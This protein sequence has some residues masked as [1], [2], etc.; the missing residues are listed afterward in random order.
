MSITPEQVAIL[1]ERVDQQNANHAELKGILIG[2]STTQGNMATQLAVM[3]TELKRTEEGKSRL[4]EITSAQDKRLD[5]IEGD[6]RVHSWTWKL[7]GSLA[8]VALTVAGYAINEF[9]AINEAGNNREKRLSLLEF[10]VG[11]RSAYPQSQTQGTKL[12]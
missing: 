12:Q 8:G 11:G 1:A 6:V 4:F 2:I 5:G 3:A 10:I 7:V 9:R